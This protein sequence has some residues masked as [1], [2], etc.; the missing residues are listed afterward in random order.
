MAD[1]KGQMALFP[2]GAPAPSPQASRPPG[3]L[4]APPL[5]PTLRMG[6][7]SWTFDGWKGL[8]YHRKYKNKQDF[9]RSSLEEYASYPLFRTV[10]IDASYYNPLTE[11]QLSAYASQLPEGFE[12]LQK[13]WDAITVPVWPNHP[14]YGEKTGQPNPS[15]LDPALFAD[16]VYGPNQAA[17]QGHM[18]PFLLEF[19]PMRPE[20]RPTARAFAEALDRFFAA[21]PRGPLYAVELRNRE[22]FTPRYLDVL[23]AHGVAHVLNLWSWMPS[24]GEQRRKA[25]VFTGPALVMRLMIGP[26]QRYEARAAEWAPFD[27]LHQVDLPHR[28]EVVDLV[29]EALGRALPVYLIVNNKFEGCS[30]LSVKGLA[31]EIARALGDR[32]AP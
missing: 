1:T 25:D 13:V 31:D 32:D 15:F 3:P 5:P 22:L 10:G 30:P 4:D 8:V 27:R 7:S 24:P 18:G 28:A 6:T 26:G 12:C 11:D 29:V 20:V 17:F 23:R 19:S 16:A 9:T 2:G 21:A 14:R